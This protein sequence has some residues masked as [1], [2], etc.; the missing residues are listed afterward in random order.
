MPIPKELTYKEE[1][2]ALKIARAKS[3]SEHPEKLGIL[4]ELGLT[5]LRMGKH[6]EAETFFQEALRGR[7]KRLGEEHSCTALSSLNLGDLHVKLGDDD[8]AMEALQEL[9]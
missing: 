3:G 9:F 5:C 7:Q 2:A 4:N 8:Q 1:R 6:A